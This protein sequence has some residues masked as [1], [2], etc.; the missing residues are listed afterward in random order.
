MRP[1]FT[2][3]QL[4]RVCDQFQL[5]GPVQ[6]AAPYGSG[7]INDTFLVTVPSAGRFILQRI[8]RNVF[9]NVPAL[10]ENIQR[11]TEHA[12]RKLR[13]APGGP[14]GGQVLTLV[15]T[16]NSRAYWTDANEQCWR[17][18]HFIEGARTHDVLQHPAQAQAAAFAFGRFQAMLADLPGARLHETIP[19][20]HHTRKRFD[21]LE[22]AIAADVRGRV[23][24][25]GR[26]IAAARERAAMA[27]RL[28]DQQASGRIPERITHN[29]TKLNNVM[30]D[31]ATGRAVCVI[32]LDTV[33]PGLALYDFGDMVRTATN[34]AAE[35]ETDLGKIHSRLPVFAALVDGYLES[36]GSFL[37]PAELDEL[38]FAG[39]LLTFENGIRF[40]TDFLQGDTYY[41]IAR[42][43][44]NFDRTRAQFALLRSME[45]QAA[46]MEA[47][48]RQHR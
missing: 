41:K 7:H 2:R 9:P 32:D 45:A 26:E 1:V 47:I 23:A 25:A 17:V 19:F 24:R 18:Y 30:L 6:D 34:S 15:P 31:D 36:A 13:A 44:H 43:D 39:R 35:D 38:V 12:T 42:P 48:V 3:E 29:D 37:L 11:V 4:A 14:A 21:A 40:L 28:V 8:N 5:P 27:D 20:F 10:M 16:R 22:R 33:M 46:D